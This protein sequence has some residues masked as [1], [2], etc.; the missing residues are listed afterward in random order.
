MLI[1]D[2]LKSSRVCFVVELISDGIEPGLVKGVTYEEKKNIN[3]L[4]F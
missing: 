3:S 1:L 2:D 4:D